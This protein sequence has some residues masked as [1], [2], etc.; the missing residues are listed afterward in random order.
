MCWPRRPRVCVIVN[1]DVLHIMLAP[2]AVFSLG[3]F[4][5]K[6][7]FFA[8]VRVGCMTTGQLTCMLLSVGP[9]AQGHEASTVVAVAL[10]G[11][12]S[13]SPLYLCADPRCGA[14]TRLLLVLTIIC[15]RACAMHAHDLPVPVYD[16]CITASS[17]SSARLVLSF[18]L[19]SSS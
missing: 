5:V 3:C 17:F 10:A 12:T 6:G 4:L 13:S 7:F 9:L 18:P 15:V 16:V 14:C 11:H 1:A 2:I 8:S 19:S